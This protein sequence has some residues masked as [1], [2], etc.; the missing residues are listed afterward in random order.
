MPAPFTMQAILQHLFQKKSLQEVPLSAL[1]QLTESYPFFVPGQLLLAK[2]LQQTY[3]E[4]FGEQ[5]L[6]TA[7]Y[8]YNPLWLQH[9]LT[10]QEPT[11]HT[12]E[13]LSDQPVESAITQTE[14]I[15]QLPVPEQPSEE[16]PVQLAGSTLTLPATA[17]MELSATAGGI[18]DEDDLLPDQTDYVHAGTERMQPL[19]KDILHTAPQN[20]TIEFQAYHTIDYF[21]SQGIQLHAGEQ[22]A[23]KLDKQLKSFT[24]WLKTM[25]RLPQAGKLQQLEKVNEEAI[26]QQASTSLE[27]R[28]VVTETMAEVLVKQQNMEKAIQIY[29]KLG[30]LYPSKK[31]YF[32]A[33]IQ[34][35]KQ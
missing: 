3:P 18:Q 7:V 23:D 32:A 29:Y 31:V 2:K 8:F 21:A 6:K 25:R 20:G 16:N 5:L 1:Q 19:L 11:A 35:L 26:Y 10:T 12:P 22:S 30:L 15:S 9:L 34:A 14:E 17:P 4:A 33:K 24:E 28:E 13:T 27:E